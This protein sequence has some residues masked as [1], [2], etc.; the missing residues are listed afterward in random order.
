MCF[1]PK[2]NK[3]AQKKIRKNITK[4]ILIRSFVWKN[5]PQFM[6]LFPPVKAEETPPPPGELPA[7]GGSFQILHRHLRGDRGRSPGVA[8]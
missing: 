8:T 1:Y 2:K 6:V 4:P 7:Q 3:R 5:G